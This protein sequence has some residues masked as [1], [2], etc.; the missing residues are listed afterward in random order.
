MASEQELF[1]WLSPT[2]WSAISSIATLL[3]VVVALFLPFYYERK[4]K[5]NLGL[6][7]EYELKKNIE[8]LKKAN[9]QADG[10]INGKIISKL[11]LM[12]PGLEHLTLNIWNESKQSIAEISSAKFL[13]YTEI[14]K[15][16]ETIKF[17]AIEITKSKGQSLFSVMLE[18]EITQCLQM[19][20]DLK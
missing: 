14:T 4:K 13:K 12:C 3:A 10:E 16:I 7:I 11:N 1:L 19:H 9:T 18:D 2:D 15:L 5:H 8:L 20:K 17:H 6:L